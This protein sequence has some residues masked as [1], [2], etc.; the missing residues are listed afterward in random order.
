MV[1]QRFSQQPKP[2]EASLQQNPSQ[3]VGHTAGEFP[4][5]LWKKAL[6]YAYDGTDYSMAGEVSCTYQGATMPHGTIAERDIP[7]TYEKGKPNNDV[8]EGQWM[9]VYGTTVRARLQLVRF[10]LQWAVRLLV[11]AQKAEV[12][13]ATLP[14]DKVWMF[15][16][17]P[18]ASK[19]EMFL[20]LIYDLVL[21]QAS[22]PAHDFVVFFDAIHDQFSLDQEQI[23]WAHVMWTYIE[24]QKVLRYVQQA[25]SAC[26]GY[27]SDMYSVRISTGSANRSK[28]LIVDEITVHKLVTSLCKIWDSIRITVFN[29]D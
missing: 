9:T 23:N 20:K 28:S 19:P 2:S 29:H 8:E 7:S 18:L 26:F 11:P 4:D 1:P 27:L 22:L 6:S 15:R 24:T 3:H 10:D 21:A 12:S 13:H 25:F 17:T 14:E 16:I 5:L